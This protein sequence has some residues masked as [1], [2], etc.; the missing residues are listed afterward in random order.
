MIKFYLLLVILT[1]W[2]TFSSAETKKSI[3]TKKHISLHNQLCVK[4]HED[5]NNLYSTDKNCSDFKMKVFN[6]DMIKNKK[7]PKT[8]RESKNS[9]QYILFFNENWECHFTRS[10]KSLTRKSLKLQNCKHKKM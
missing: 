6:S 8:L 7:R 9:S 4:L 5:E 10:N 1:T 2:S 3:K